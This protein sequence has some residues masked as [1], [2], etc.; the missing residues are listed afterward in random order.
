MGSMVAH[1]YQLPS[2]RHILLEGARSVRLYHFNP[3][4]SVA[5]ANSEFRD[6]SDVAVYGTKSEGSSATLWVRNCTGVVHTG[7]AG[8]AN[9]RSC[10]DAK[11]CAAWPVSPC[12][13][14]YKG[15][16]S[17]FRV[18]GCRDCRF[19]NL[20]SQQT[21]PPGFAALWASLPGGGNLSSAKMEAPAVVVLSD[22]L[23][24]AREHG[25]IRCR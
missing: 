22:T 3:E 19:G 14:D 23:K 25:T 6:A 9:P 7:H 2:Y 13:C 24:C 12:A 17:L 1:D 21:K 11:A 15:V 10:A 4:H 20:W 18:E 5:N 16:P 8:N